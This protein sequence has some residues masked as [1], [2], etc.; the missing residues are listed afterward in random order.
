[1]KIFIWYV[2]Y[3][4][5]FKDS[6]FPCLSQNLKQKLCPLYM[7]LI[8]DYNVRV[9][10][11]LGHRRNK[12]AIKR[13]HHPLLVEIVMDGTL[14]KTIWLLYYTKSYT[15]NWLSIWLSN[16]TSLHLPKWPKVLLTK[17]IYISIFMTLFIIAKIWI[18]L[19]CP[20]TDN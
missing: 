10:Y 3:D 2:T 7:F 14:W 15:K 18:K 17:D 20:R 16:S 19:T 4:I 6:S 9:P 8:M 12:S 5:L 11:V 1:M 13:N